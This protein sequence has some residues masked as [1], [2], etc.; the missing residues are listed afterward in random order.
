MSEHGHGRFL[1]Q[2]LELVLLLL[3]L[4]LIIREV[5]DRAAVTRPLLPKQVFEVHLGQVLGH[6]LEGQPPCREPRD[7]RAW[8]VAW[9]LS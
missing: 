5:H 3:I 9:F 6:D 4:A 8:I 7:R 1:L 2:E